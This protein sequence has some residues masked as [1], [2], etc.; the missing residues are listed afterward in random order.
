MFNRRFLMKDGS[1]EMLV[2]VATRLS[3]EAYQ[4]LRKSKQKN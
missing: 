3:T 1:G 2:D 4:T